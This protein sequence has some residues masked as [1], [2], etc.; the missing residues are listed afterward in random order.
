[1]KRPSFACVDD[2]RLHVDIL[3]QRGHVADAFHETR[4]LSEANVRDDLL[5]HLF[6]RCVLQSHTCK[7][8]L[9]LPLD[10]GEEARLI[11][12]SE[13]RV[14]NHVRAVCLCLYVVSVHVCLVVTTG[15][16]VSGPCGRVA[17]RST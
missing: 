4:A 1:M 13:C 9:Q 3:V 15:C 6:E 17:Y 16:R 7:A 5:T 10:A 12:V 14:T 2:I 11:S 8:L